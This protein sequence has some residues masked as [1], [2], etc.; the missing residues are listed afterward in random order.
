MGVLGWA[1]L[2]QTPLG[3]VGAPSGGGGG[4]V[5]G[6]AVLGHM[7]LGQSGTTTALTA[8][9]SPDPRCGPDR[10]VVGDTIAI[11]WRVTH[12]VDGCCTPVTPTTVTAAITHENGVTVDLTA[13][14]S[15]VDTGVYVV[16]WVPAIAGRL[17]ATLTTTGPGAGVT[18]VILDV[19]EIGLALPT[20]AELRAYVAPSG[21]SDAELA[22]ALAVE[23]DDQ[24]EWCRIDPYTPALR[25]ALFRRVAKHLAAK[26]V[27]TAQVTSFGQGTA[28]GP[29]LAVALD[30]EIERLE[31]SRRR[32]GFA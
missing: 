28:A 18:E 17:V 11:V 2:G 8:W 21:A 6:Y 15:E 19:Q 29:V 13:S 9:A 22:E 20:I 16:G 24:A 4:A 10:W 25:T 5:L 7:V 12:D 1:V 27:P 31:R 32:I 26:R 3:T 30:A 23:R 14:L